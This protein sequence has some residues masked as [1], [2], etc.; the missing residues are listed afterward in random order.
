MAETV[1]GGEEGRRTKRGMDG[2]RTARKVARVMKAGLRRRPERPRRRTAEAGGT[3][4]LREMLKERLNDRNRWK[5]RTAPG[6]GGRPRRMKW[7]TTLE[8]KPSGRACQ[9]SPVG[10]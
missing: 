3:Y 10:I 4:L 8:G 7:K 1:G 5:G 2:K 6:G 9:Q